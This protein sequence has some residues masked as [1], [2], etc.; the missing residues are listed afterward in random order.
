MRNF[1]NYHPESPVWLTNNQKPSGKGRPFSFDDK[2]PLKCL[3][4]KEV[5]FLLTT[6]D[7]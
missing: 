7:L 3:Y 4:Q 2:V 1:Y 5:D 6:R